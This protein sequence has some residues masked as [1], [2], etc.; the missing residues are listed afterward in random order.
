ME[1]EKST[2]KK[3]FLNMQERKFSSQEFP[4]PGELSRDWVRKDITL[5][6]LWEMNPQLY[7]G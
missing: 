2:V 6:E 5:K 1:T 3:A 4:I 7:V